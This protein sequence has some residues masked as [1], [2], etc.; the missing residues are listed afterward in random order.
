MLRT[1]DYLSWSQYS[2]FNKSKKEYWKRYG[3]GQESKSNK[4]FNKGKEI[5]E[6]LETGKLPDYEY[7]PLLKM[8]AEQVPKLDMMEDK[9]EVTID[10]EKLLAFVDSGALDGS[11]FMEYKSGKVPWNQN[12]VDTHEQL[13]FYALCYYIKNGIIPKCTL[14]WIETEEIKKEDS[15]SEIKYTGMVH[16]FERNFILSDIVRMQKKIL[17]TIKDIENFD[18]TEM[19][20]EDDVM[21]RYLEIQQEISILTKEAGDIKAVIYM[22]MHA[23][24]VNYAS[25]TNGRFSMASRKSWNY[26]P[27][28]TAKKLKYDSEVKGEQKIEQKNEIATFTTTTSLRFQEIKH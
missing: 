24:E 4:Y 19:E 14:V 21:D 17:K 20:V 7:D 3:L 26:S 9:L 6:Y 15:Y 11:E 22:E 16:T 25:G 5:G 10:G 13:D 12:L 27:E 28:L 8:V 18:Y 2:L 23:D 1:K